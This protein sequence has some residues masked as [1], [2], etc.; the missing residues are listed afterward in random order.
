VEGTIMNG[1]VLEDQS[2]APV[3]WSVSFAGPNPKEKDC[4]RCANREEAVKLMWRLKLFQE[5]LDALALALAEHGH[6]WSPEEREKYER[7]GVSS[8]C[9]VTG[10]SA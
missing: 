8:G 7:A 2:V 6:R 1:F 9:R 10:S 5:A 4:V 3:A